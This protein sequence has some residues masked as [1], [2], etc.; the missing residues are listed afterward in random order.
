M[1]EQLK[2]FKT[3]TLAFEVIDNFSETDEKFAQ[4]LF[5][6]KLAKGFK[7]VNVLIK[8]DEY[9]LSKTETKAFFEDIV[10]VLRNYKDMGHLAIVAHSKVLKALV[11]I[12]N[13]FF[14]RA[15]KGRKEQYFD[16]SQLDEAFEFVTKN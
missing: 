6:E 14:E 15:S 9:K 5:K 11:P 7:T 2:T 16:V 12:D 13:L 3:N 1:L 4:K 10:F 8:I